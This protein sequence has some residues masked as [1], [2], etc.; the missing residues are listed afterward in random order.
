[1][2]GKNSKSRGDKNGMSH[3]KERQMLTIAIIQGLK[4]KRIEV[5]KNLILKKLARAGFKTSLRTLERDIASIAATDAGMIMGKR[6]SRLST[7]PGTRY[8][9][10]IRDE[11]DKSFFM[12]KKWKIAG[13]R[14]EKSTLQHKKKLDRVMNKMDKFKIYLQNL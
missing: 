1:M 7:S 13:K 10:K 8:I 6:Y 5:D 9:K 2:S 12:S 4:D 11:H 14:M 3:I